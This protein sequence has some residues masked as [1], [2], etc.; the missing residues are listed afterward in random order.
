MSTAYTIVGD[1]HARNENLDQIEELFMLIEKLGNDTI[2]LGDLL[3]NKE[4]VSGKCLNTYIRCMKASNLKF[5]VLVGNHDYFSTECT[6]HSL[7]SLKELPNVTVV[8]KP[9]IVEN[10]LLLP[11]Y[12][13][14]NLFRVVAHYAQDQDV[15]TLIM[16]QGVNKCDY[17][18]GFI[19][20][21]EIEL[22]ELAHFK[23]VISGHFHKYQERGN[24]IYIG[25]PF[26]QSFGE[27]N[28]IKYVGAFTNQANHFEVIPTDFPK[29]MTYEVDCDE[30]QMLLFTP[31]DKD[32]N[33]VILKGSR[34]NINKFNRVFY[35]T[36]RFIE[37]P[38]LE[39]AASPVKES[40]APE[41]QFKNW[42]KE[43]KKLD[44]QT[45]DLG[46]K[47]IKDIQ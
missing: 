1:P 29:H 19:A 3:H 40:D 2:I 10:M 18:N 5:H 46:L 20:E 26:S 32:Y 4:V 37:Q 17:G 27:S 22:E 14:L 23:R 7:Q 33:R 38:T 15:D 39:I 28:Q 8:D 31:N 42:A 36:V 25:T 13:D 11:Y 34:H 30:Q 41:T 47:I 21:N 16:H 24:L 12:H 45:I 9:C 43:I 44:Q 6:D 35:P